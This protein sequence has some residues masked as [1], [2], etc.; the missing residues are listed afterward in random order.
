VGLSRLGGR[1][2]SRLVQIMA[3]SIAHPTVQVTLREEAG[4]VRLFVSGDLDRDNAWALTAAVMRSGVT[5]PSRL[6]VDLEQLKFID[7]GGLR[8]ITD[9]ARRARRRSCGFA[10]A[11]PSEPVERLFRLTG[12]DRALNVVTSV[13]DER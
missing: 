4:S 11:N 3:R 6:V 10:V 12:V 5:Q 2:G 1:P 7:V 8:A 13:G 9:A